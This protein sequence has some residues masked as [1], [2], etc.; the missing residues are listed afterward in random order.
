MNIFLPIESDVAKSVECLDDIRLNKQA[1]E[2]YQ[3]L[4]SALAEKN[5]TKINEHNHH[6]VYLFYKNNPDFLAYYGLCC[7][8]EYGERSG[9][10][11][12]HSLHNFFVECCLERLDMIK[13]LSFKRPEYVPYYMEGSKTSP[14]AIR[15]TECVSDLFKAKLIKKWEHD[16]IAPTWTKRGLPEFYKTYLDLSADKKN[17]YWKNIEE[18][19]RGVRE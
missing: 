6:P 8:T 14:D 15:T 13:F 3:L 16:K 11:K 7:T 18:I 17:D 5:H 9:N 2:C 12:T 19:K 1:L 10:I 4:T